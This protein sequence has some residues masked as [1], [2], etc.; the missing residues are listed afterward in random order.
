MTIQWGANQARPALPRTIAFA[1]PAVDEHWL[2]DEWMGLAE[3]YARRKQA[4]AITPDDGELARRRA[5]RKA[6]QQV[7][8]DKPSLAQR[9][10]NIRARIA[11]GQDAPAFRCYGPTDINESEEKK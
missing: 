1:V 11:A 10:A 9:I 5:L 3:T 8:P 4:S 7:P 2:A 6:L